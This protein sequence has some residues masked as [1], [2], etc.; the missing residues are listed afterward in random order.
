MPCNIQIIHEFWQINQVK[1]TQ[2]PTQKY[3]R[4]TWYHHCK[5]DFVAVSCLSTGILVIFYSFWLF[6]INCSCRWNDCHSIYLDVVI[7]LSIIQS[8]KV[9]K[10]VRRSMILWH[11]VFLWRRDGFHMREL[12][13]RFHSWMWSSVTCP[14][15]SRRWAIN[16]ITSSIFKSIGYC[17][18][19]VRFLHCAAQNSLKIRFMQIPIETGFLQSH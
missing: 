10:L 13:Q 17:P 5:Y 18:P 8:V 3:G 11:F 9:Q 7:V 19:H 12:W 16:F 14:K 2:L 1:T 4:Q 15:G 6:Y